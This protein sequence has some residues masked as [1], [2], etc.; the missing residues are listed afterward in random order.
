MH[1][2]PPHIN[3]FRSTQRGTVQT[4]CMV[5]IVLTMSALYKEATCISSIFDSD[6]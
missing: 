4:D 1:G 3:T 5:C 6:E 2:D